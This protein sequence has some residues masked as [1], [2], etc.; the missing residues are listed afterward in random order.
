MLTKGGSRGRPAPKCTR[1]YMPGYG[2]PGGSKGLFPWKWAEERLSKSHNY[3]VATSRPEGKPHLMIVWGLWMGGAFYFST[4]R[5]SRKAKN[6]AHRPHCVIATELAHQAVIVEGVAEEVQDV[7]FRRRYL[8]A[9]ERKY[10]FDMSAFEKDI[11]S[12]KEPIYVVLPAVVFGLDE[13]KSLAAATRWR[14]RER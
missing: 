7:G 2:L 11:L 1:P 13:K 3:W 5:Q 12:L 10:K 8:E 9:A 4:G 6:L 14:F